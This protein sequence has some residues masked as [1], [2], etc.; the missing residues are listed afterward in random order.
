MEV[1]NETVFS[2]ARVGQY[3]NTIASFLS[4][5]C[6]RGGSID[7][8]TSPAHLYDNQYAKAAAAYD[9]KDDEAPGSGRALLIIEGQYLF[10]FDFDPIGGYNAKLTKKEH[11]KPNSIDFLDF[12]YRVSAS[13]EKR[14]V[15]VPC[16]DYRPDD[17]PYDEM[18]VLICKSMI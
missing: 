16:W 14:T 2:R 13:P 15:V 10:W 3:W 18:R 9:G 11:R 6:N 17:D 4:Q 12:V 7:P 8:K 5:W 1:N